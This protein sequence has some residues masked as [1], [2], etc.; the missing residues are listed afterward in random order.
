MSLYS[1]PGYNDEFMSARDALEEWIS[2]QELDLN[3]E[4]SEIL[5]QATRSQSTPEFNLTAI[6]S[7]ADY[8][9]LDLVAI[10]YPLPTAHSVIYTIGHNTPGYLPECEILQFATAVDAVF[11]YRSELN[12]RLDQMG[13][14]TP[15]AEDSY[16]Q[17]HD[18]LLFLTHAQVAAGLKADK[19]FNFAMGGEVYWVHETNV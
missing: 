14:G 19:F 7:G 16:A 17:A 4:D 6:Q 8:L 12:D 15:E 5:Y 13:D 2:S 9:G 3:A 1:F 10:G 11:S 18:A